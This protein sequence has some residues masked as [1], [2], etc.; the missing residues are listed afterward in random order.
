MI[1]YFL[2][3]IIIVTL[4]SSCKKEVNN[5]STRQLITEYNLQSFGSFN[6]FGKREENKWFSMDSTLIFTLY[7]NRNTNHFLYLV[8]NNKMD[9][10]YKHI[11]STRFE[12]TIRDFFK[13]KENYF[14]TLWNPALKN[15][16]GYPS[17]YNF[18][19]YRY[20][21]LYTYDSLNIYLVDSISSNLEKINKP[22]I[23]DIAD[24]FKKT[25][26]LGGEF[27][28]IKSDSKIRLVK[29]T[30]EN[31]KILFQSD[32]GLE[33]VDKE[34]AHLSPY[35]FNKSKNELDKN[36]F[37]SFTE[38]FLISENIKGD[39]KCY[40][41][42]DKEYNNLGISKIDFIFYQFNE[43]HIIPT[44]LD[45]LFIIDEEFQIR[46]IDP[47]DS[48]YIES[49]KYVNGE[50][51]FYIHKQ[52]TEH[53]SG[54]FPIIYHI[55]TINWEIERIL[56]FNFE[57]T[58]KLKKLKTTSQIEILS[59]IH[60]SNLSNILNEFEIVKVNDEYRLI[61]KGI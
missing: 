24:S 9:T 37:S 1:K 3:I 15:Y 16:I 40:Y 38:N 53:W 59:N 5:I 7:E 55:D 39:I 54:G 43:E 41:S 61:K 12:L 57:D 10:I 13:T 4:F 27:E 58:K 22:K 14:V 11:D 52:S 31:Q 34:N 21:D 20:E 49:F 18:K 28:I 30:L 6:S 29:D 47:F 48:F 25:Y 51:F 26:K 60:R 56:P 35:F 8:Q 50:Y 46:N 32:V 33:I 36:S 44:T 17:D 42:Y 2:N 19:N 45:N 23:N